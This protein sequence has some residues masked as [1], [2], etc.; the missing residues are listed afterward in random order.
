MDWISLV[1]IAAIAAIVIALVFD[2]INGFHDTANAVAT[3]IYSGAMKPRQAIL[4]S[5]FLNFLGAVTVGTS[6]ALF[7]TKIIP[8][9]ECSLSLVTAALLAGVLWNLL[10]WYKGL[11]VSSSHC[12][13]GSLVGAGIAA[14][15]LSGVDFHVLYTAI[16][17]L[18]V[19][20]LLGFLV[21]MV[22]AFI[23]KRLIGEDT[24]SRMTCVKRALPWVQIVSSASVSYSHGANDGQKTMGIITLILATHFA[25]AGYSLEHVPFWVVVSAA[26]AIGLGTAIGGWRVIETVGKNLSNKPLDPAH[27]CAA[28]FTTAATVFGASMVGVPVSTTHVLTSSVIGGTYGLHGHGHANMGTIK[29]IIYAWFLTLP[30]TVVLSGA[31]YLLFSLFV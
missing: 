17:A 25:W 23:I 16:I 30:V 12:L 19:S 5:A 29:K 14:A 31:L 2:F 18:L 9:S 13:L 24:E 26:S 8:L 11:P 27:G 3:V 20:P 22:V 28:E 1:D 4:M 7:I 15:G 6:V 21:A 10:T